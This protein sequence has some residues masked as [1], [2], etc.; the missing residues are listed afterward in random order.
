MRLY[1]WITESKHSL[2][3][4]AVA[5]M[6]F[7][8]IISM[9][10]IAN[11]GDR[12]YTWGDGTA[13]TSQVR[14]SRSWPA[15]FDVVFTHS[16]GLVFDVV[17]LATIA[18]GLMLMVGF[19]TRT[20]TVLSLLLWMS[21]YVTNPFVGSGGDAVLRMSMLYLCFM[22][23]GRH[24]SI[25]AVVRRRSARRPG[26]T[27]LSAPVSHAFHNA[28]LVLILHQ[29]IIV[30]VCSALW[31]VQSPRWTDGTAVYYPLQV[32]A[33]SPWRDHIHLL[34]DHGW[35]VMAGTYG[36]IGV[37]LLLPVLIL[38]KPSRVF[39]L[40]S[41][42]GMHLG[43]GVFM[44]ILFFSLVMIAADALLISDESWQ[45]IALRVGRWVGGP[46]ANATRSH[47]TDPARQ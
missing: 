35:I 29:I 20:A 39:T 15:V 44:G 4:A 40:L 25:D 14:G 8:F 18:V 1:S 41:I 37:Q 36:A 13:W 47:D 45:A 46:R 30:Y 3:G 24:W 32:E 9:Q 23:S 22:D 16:D 11:A 2:Y 12:H 10:L 21:L 33:Y 34:T 43:I 28:G 38:Y 26:R 19:F 27:F 42:L 7:G 17:Y 31:K 6:L 5:R